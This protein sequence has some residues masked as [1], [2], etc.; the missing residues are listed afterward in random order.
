M[1][2]SARAA[3]GPAATRHAPVTS[4]R[5]PMNRGEKPSARA[6]TAMQTTYAPRQSRLSRYA[7]TRIEFSAAA[8]STSSPFCTPYAAAAP[9]G[10]PTANVIAT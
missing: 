6:E 8:A 10:N 1:S 3:N 5:P 7:K 9:A 2:C 4:P